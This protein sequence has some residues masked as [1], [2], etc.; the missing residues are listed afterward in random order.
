M[1]V[2][3]L[4]DSGTDKAAPFMT[5]SGYVGPTHRWATFERSAAQIFAEFGVTILHAKEFND[6]KGDFANWPRRKKEQFAARLYLE[7][8]NAASFGV[9]ASIARTA[10]AKSK[11]IGGHTNQSPYG[12]CFGEVLNQI[13]Y[14]AATK[15]AVANH[16]ATLS[17]VVEAGNKNDADLVRMF[18]EEKWSPRHTGVETVLK[19]VAFAD[20]SSTIALQMADSLAFHA[21][22]HALQCERAQ[23]YLPLSDLQKIIFYAVPTAN[24]V[25]HEFLTN[26]EIEQGY[27]ERSRWRASSPWLWHR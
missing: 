17:F 14:S 4:D 7:L 11:S 25:S 21:R 20:K 6:T 15:M 13:M 18:N 5:M 3:Y 2:C 8:R 12:Y 23:R 1:M 22:R 24:S 19:S 16:G 27:T 26:Q 9:S 10:Y